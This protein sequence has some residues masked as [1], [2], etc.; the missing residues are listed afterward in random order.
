MGLILF[1][2]K[3]FLIVL[4][5]VL[6]L[7]LLL[8]GLILLVPIHYEVT[9][10]I[11]DSWEIQVKGK[12]TYLL[13]MLK[14]FF[15]YEK[16]QFD[17]K[18]FIFGFQKKISEENISETSANDRNI[19]NLEQEGINRKETGSEEQVLFSEQEQF[20]EDET[21]VSEPV[22]EKPDVSDTDE[23]KQTQVRS[24]KEK[25]QSIKKKQKVKKKKIKQ[26][27][28]KIDFAFIKQELTDEHNKSVVK[29]FFT[30]LLY[31]LRHFKFR[32]IITDLRFST[33]DPAYTGQ[34]LGILCMIPMLYRYDFKIVPDFEGEEAYIKG[35]F[36]VSGK[37]RL[38]HILITCLRLIFDKEVRLIVKKISTLLEN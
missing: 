34:V 37:V 38:I 8:S 32:K 33:G 35:T 9:G 19:K 13:S 25:K 23:R 29:K 2:L 26:E 3:I 14:L 4:L 6:G 20:V 36:L 15:S 30:E 31:L 18:V 1:I 12:V 24:K 7:I 5:T 10:N 27:K 17:M 28:R 21:S 16:E 11:G 22:S